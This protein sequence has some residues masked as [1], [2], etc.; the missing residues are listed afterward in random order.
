MEAFKKIKGMDNIKTDY[1]N[2]LNQIHSNSR[3]Q[4]SAVENLLKE[5]PQ[6]LVDDL[7]RDNKRTQELKDQLIDN[8]KK[9]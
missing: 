2:D 9:S 6:I 8:L 5:L 3:V 1:K 4:T 7:K